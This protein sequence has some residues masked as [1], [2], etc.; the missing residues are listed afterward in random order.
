MRADIEAWMT[1]VAPLWPLTCGHEGW[2]FEKH[3]RVCHR[4]QMMLVDFGD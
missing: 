4:C 2:S 3:G 1:A